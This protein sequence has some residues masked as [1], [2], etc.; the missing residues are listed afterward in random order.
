MVRQSVETFKRD[1]YSS[2]RG[3]L[4]VILVTV[5]VVRTGETLGTV[6]TVVTVVTVMTVV[7]DTKFVKL[8]Y[9]EQLQ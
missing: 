9:K 5:M 8:G 6:K 2:F 1:I 3:Y 7:T 4:T